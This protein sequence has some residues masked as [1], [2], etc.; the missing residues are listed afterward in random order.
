MTPLKYRKDLINTTMIRNPVD[1]Y[2]SNFLYIYKGNN[3]EKD[4]D[5]WLYNPSIYN[6]QSNL[7]TK[8]LSSYINEEEYNKKTHGLERANFGWCLE[9]VDLNVAKQ[10][11]DSCDIVGIFEDHQS[12]LN[13]YNNLLL[14]TF[15]F[16]TFPNR[17]KINGNFSKIIIS[18]TMK[19]RI[20]DINSLDMELYEYAKNKK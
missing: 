19:S 8:C 1:R 2:L 3:F 15:G 7:Q 17:N 9:S 11:I 18:D 5:E 12:F 13:K 14:K 10:T 4:F 16:T 20:E 6:I